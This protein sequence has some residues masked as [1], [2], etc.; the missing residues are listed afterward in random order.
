MNRLQPLPRGLGRGRAAA[1]GGGGGCVQ[2]R[3]KLPPADVERLDGVLSG[4]PRLQQ[5]QLQQQQQPRRGSL[6]SPGAAA[7]A[8]RARLPSLAGRNRGAG[9]PAPPRAGGPQPEPQPL[10]LTASSLRRFQAL[11]HPSFRAKREA[12]GPKATRAAGLPARNSL[13]PVLYPFTRP[14]AVV[15]RI[16]NND[17][18]NPQ[19]AASG[20]ASKTSS[21]TT[22]RQG[23]STVRARTVKR[24]ASK[25]EDDA[26]NPF[27]LPPLG[28]SPA[29]LLPVRAVLRRFERETRAEKARRQRLA[30]MEARAP[31][32]TKTVDEALRD[33]LPPLGQAVPGLANALDSSICAPSTPPPSGAKLRTFFAVVFALLGTVRLRGLL[34][35]KRRRRLLALVNGLQQQRAAHTALPAAGLKTLV[36]GFKAFAA[37]S[38][39]GSVNVRTLQAAGV[40]L[41]VHLDPGLL[42]K[43]DRDKDGI[44]TFPELLRVVYPCVPRRVL[45]D[46]V[47]AVTRNVESAWDA[48]FTP[49]CLR[50][51]AAVF[52]YMTRSGSTRLT[53][54]VFLSFAP[55]EGV[56]EQELYAQFC[57][58]DS[59][60][61]GCLSF[62]EYALFM[63]AAFTNEDDVL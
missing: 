38:L 33:A 27:H 12:A 15:G 29:P 56:T 46:A 13:G 5:R 44:V 51:I 22:G 2:F 48:L 39:L 30:R 8:G 31:V 60:C 26:G 28:A 47:K 17:D 6:P 14:A 61:D 57:E 10:K 53:F 52:R 1:A 59:D 34:R 35:A 16:D 37:G 42:K 20:D 63:R 41:D 45:E 11:S 7:P 49:E 43:L 40:K 32:S 50:D 58:A 24:R 3:D 62:Q 9:N 54:P 23:S 55:S 36:H 25:V 19:G 21:L 18:E 4:L